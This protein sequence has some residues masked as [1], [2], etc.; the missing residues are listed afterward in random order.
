MLL[1]LVK[2]YWNPATPIYYMLSM[3]VFLLQELSI[4]DCMDHRAENID[5]LALTEKNLLTSDLGHFFLVP[6]K[7][8]NSP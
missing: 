2:L 8:N 6:L 7:R 5:H 3:V 1:V 4:R